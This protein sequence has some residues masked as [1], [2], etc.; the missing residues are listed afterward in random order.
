MKT[1]EK[2]Q[3]E[4]ALEFIAWLISGS[5]TKL[6]SFRWVRIASLEAG[7][8]GKSSWSTPTTSWTQFT[9]T[10]CCLQIN[11]D[12]IM[13]YCLHLF[14]VFTHPVVVVWTMR[15]GKIWSTWV[16]STSMIKTV[17]KKLSGKA[18]MRMI[19]IYPTQ[20]M[21]GDRRSR[22]QFRIRLNT[23][24]SICRKWMGHSVVL[25]ISCSWSLIPDCWVLIRLNL[26]QRYVVVIWLYMFGCFF[27]A[28]AFYRY[29]SKIFK[30]SDRTYYE[31]TQSCDLI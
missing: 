2:S 14:G 22:V 13:I 9:M 8:A 7:M 15:L 3:L 29:F 25:L 6:I 23:I 10:L 5:I 20:Q 17:R 27:S 4:T 1:N 28:F 12:W 11:M 19:P 31:N 26:I 16:K 30:L 18:S 21:N 24:G